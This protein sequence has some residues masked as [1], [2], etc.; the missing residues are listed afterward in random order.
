[1][2]DT[3]IYAP[4]SRDRTAERERCESDIPGYREERHHPTWREIRDE[5]LA[6]IETARIF[7]KDK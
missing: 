1:M 5:F 2:T 4:V 3:D 6:D 7:A